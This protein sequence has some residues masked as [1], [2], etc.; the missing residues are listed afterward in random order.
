ME[1]RLARW[2]LECRDRDGGADT[3]T[4]TQEYMASMLGVQRTVN[5]VLQELRARGLITLEAGRLTS[6]TG[7]DCRLWAISSRPT[8]TP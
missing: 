5:R 8:S 7:P 6:S 2:L 4:T 3:L 1:Q